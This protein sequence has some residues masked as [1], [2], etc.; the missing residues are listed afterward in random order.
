M[1]TDQSLSGSSV[2]ASNARTLHGGAVI[3]IEMVAVSEDSSTPEGLARGLLEQE[4]L[5][6]RI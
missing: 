4:A 2:L 6:A 1:E 5:D 3:E